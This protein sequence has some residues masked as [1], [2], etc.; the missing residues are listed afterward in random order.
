MNKHTAFTLI[1]LLVVISIIALLIALL[2][3]ALGTARF[4]AQISQCSSNF[5]QAGLA[6]GNYAVDFKGQLPTAD[7]ASSHGPN[8]NLIARSQME[9]MLDYGQGSVETWFCP[10]R[11][12]RVHDTLTLAEV[13]STPEDMLTELTLFGGDAVVFPQSWY[14][15]RRIGA[16]APTPVDMPWEDA[17]NAE[18]VWPVKIDDV[19]RDGKPIMTDM[20]TARNGEPG[21]TDP[22]FT[23]GGH[24]RGGPS[25]EGGTQSINRLHVDGSVVTVPA[26][27]TIEHL[28]QNTWMN[29]R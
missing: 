23:W 11:G 3:P 21:F 6:V 26:N 7:I 13:P 1:E 22:G 12:T 15:H 8:P 27:E 25:I 16:S 18:E 4:T 29:W 9:V 2:L 19:R 28:V 14:V 5:H 24:R 20:M 10:T 17:G